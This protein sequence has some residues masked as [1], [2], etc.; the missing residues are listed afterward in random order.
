MPYEVEQ[1]FPVDDLA[2]VETNLLSLGAEIG[3]AVIEVDRYFNHPARDFAETDEAVRV[4]RKGDQHLVTYK[5]PKIDTT[6][7]TRRE[8]ELPLPGEEGT[9]EAWSEWLTALG[10]RVVGEVCKQRRRAHVE[11][12]GRS[13]EVT[14][15]QVDSLGE[16]VELELVADEEGL[17]AARACIASL[18]ESLGL[19]TSERRSY[20]TLVLAKR[21]AES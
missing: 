8:I 3:P 21:E 20:L 11:H 19:T 7:K 2:A 12:D 5:G 9:V 10:F 15:D 17:N 14:L 16:F 4:R 18:A 1:K 6:T 13:I